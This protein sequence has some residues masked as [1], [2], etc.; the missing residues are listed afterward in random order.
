MG[1][2]PGLAPQGKES[3]PLDSF[4]RTAPVAKLPKVKA[5]LTA[6]G[7]LVYSFL[8]GKISRWQKHF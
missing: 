2:R 8:Q 3:L 4:T 1:R 6:T 7:T 5:N